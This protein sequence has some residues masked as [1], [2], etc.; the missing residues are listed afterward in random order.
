MLLL[1]LGTVSIRC[2]HFLAKTRHWKTLPLKKGQTLSGPW[3]IL[4]NTFING[5]TQLNSWTWDPRPNSCRVKRPFAESTLIIVFVMEWIDTGPKYSIYRVCSE[6]ACVL[7]YC[8]LGGMIDPPLHALAHGN[9][10][11]FSGMWESMRLP[12]GHASKLLHGSDTV[13]H[14]PPAVAHYISRLPYLHPH[15]SL[16]LWSHTT[17][18]AECHLIQESY[19]T[20]IR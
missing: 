17:L 15:V 18:C 14:I 9:H 5:S 4:Y 1:V 6:C 11:S 7:K 2:S 13:L 8:K 16:P 12:D 3:L 19:A 10:S 20:I